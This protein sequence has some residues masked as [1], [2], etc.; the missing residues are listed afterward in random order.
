MRLV[1]WKALKIMIPLSRMEIGRKEKA[2][3]FLKR[4]RIGFR[5]F[6]VYDEVTDWIAAHVANR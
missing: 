5:V 6:W 3:K 4:V 1:D 2:G